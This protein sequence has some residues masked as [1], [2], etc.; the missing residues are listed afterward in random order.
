VDDGDVL[1]VLSDDGE[2]DEVHRDAAMSIAWSRRSI[3]SW[4]DREVRLEELRA[5]G[6]FG[7]R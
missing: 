7:R 3:A 6:C 5:L 1:E 2:V 4:S